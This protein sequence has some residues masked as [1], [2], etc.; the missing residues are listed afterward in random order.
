MLTVAKSGMIISKKP[1][2]WKNDWE[3]IWRRNVNQTLSL[4]R[5][6][7]KKKSLCHPRY[8]EKYHRSRRQ[9]STATHKHKWVYQQ[10]FANNPKPYSGR[11]RLGIG[12]RHS[13][14]CFHFTVVLHTGNQ[15]GVWGA[16]AGSPNWH[17][18]QRG[19]PFTHTPLS[20]SAAYTNQREMYT[21]VACINNIPASLQ[22]RTALNTCKYPL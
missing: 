16:T 9:F 4:Y 22:Y 10:N 20:C 3:N 2:R 5:L 18:R 12:C 13:G 11:S 6:K 1:F 15:L 17:V 7:F 21:L 14:Q 8:C 19:C